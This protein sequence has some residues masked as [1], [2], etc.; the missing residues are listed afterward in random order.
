MAP[1]LRPD[2]NSSLGISFSQVPLIFYVLVVKK[3]YIFFFF[4]SGQ[5]IMKKY[6][7]C[8]F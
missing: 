3:I 1:T 7:V 6:F 5:T 8:D 4:F 2:P